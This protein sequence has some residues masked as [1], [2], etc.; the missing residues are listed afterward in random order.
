MAAM[1]GFFC[2]NKQAEGLAFKRAVVAKI[3]QQSDPPLKERPDATPHASDNTTR[4]DAA[5]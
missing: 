3:A 4:I 5:A 2:A 1:A